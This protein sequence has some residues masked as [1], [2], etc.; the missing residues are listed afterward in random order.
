MIYLLCSQSSEQQ[1]RYQIWNFN[2]FNKW[3]ILSYHMGA[4]SPRQ[5]FSVNSVTIFIST[6]VLV[7]LFEKSMHFMSILL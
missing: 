2:L 3:G 7:S 6:T 5:Q 1:F 4:L